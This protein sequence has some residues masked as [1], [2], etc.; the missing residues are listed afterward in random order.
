MLAGATK[1]EDD[2]SLRSAVGQLAAH[3]WPDSHELPPSEPMLRFLDVERQLALKHEIDLLLTLVSVYASPLARLEDNEVQ[4]EG[5]HPQ[6]AAQWL[7]A[8][9]AVRFQR[10]EG[11]IQVGHAGKTTRSRAACGY[12]PSRGRRVQTD[13]WGAFVRGTFRSSR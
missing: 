13:G 9:I 5:T 12:W 8:I 1:C 2:Q 11:K 10:G 6:L 4:A 7:E 3:R